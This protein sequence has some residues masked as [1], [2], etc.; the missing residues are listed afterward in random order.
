MKKNILLL[1]LLLAFS[2]SLMMGQAY[3]WLFSLEQPVQSETLSFSDDFIAIT[4]IMAETQIGFDIQNKTN[5]GIKINWDDL[6]FIYPGGRSTRV[7]HSGIRLMDR[8]IPQATTIIPPNARVSDILIPS[9]NINNNSG[10]WYTEPLFGG[11]NRLIWNDKEF[12]IYF[13]LEISG[14]KKE[15]IFKFKVNISL[16]PPVYILPEPEP[17]FRIKLGGATFTGRGY[18]FSYSFAMYD[19]TAKYEYS[20]ADKSGVGVCG[21][22]GVLVLPNVEVTAD[23]FSG[24]TELAG[25]Y[26][27]SLPN[28]YKYNMIATGTSSKPSKYSLSNWCFGANVHFKVSNSPV[29]FYVGGGISGSTLKLDMLEE[30][31]FR[32]TYSNYVNNVEIASVD[33]K[34]I[35]IS[36]IGVALRGG[37]TYKI[38]KNIGLFIEGRYAPASGEVSEVLLKNAGVD[39]KIKLDFGGFKG[40]GGLLISI[41]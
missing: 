20:L 1:T 3:N 26:S 13:P 16:P 8:N 9:E 14:N 31:K 28:P 4:F 40:I 35:S 7:I 12:S 18:D 25:D 27:G 17:K 5:G 34:N 23:Y 30:L 24:S 39:R 11:D 29:S 37:V 22:F 38:V 33:L 41:I 21:G 2:P 10:G 15:Y 32:Q 6:S 19:E 36:K